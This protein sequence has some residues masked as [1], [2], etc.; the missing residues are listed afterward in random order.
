MEQGNI[1]YADD[2]G[3]DDWD[4]E[5]QEDNEI[6][7]SDSLLV[8]AM[9]E[10]EFSHLEVQVFSEDG[11]LFVHHDITLPDFPLSLAWMDCP[12]FATSA[13]GS[14]STVGN[15]IAVGTFSPAIEIWNLDV[16]DPLEPTAILGGENTAATFQKKQKQNKNGKKSKTIQQVA[17]TYLP[18]SHEAAVMSLSW[19]STFR[20]ALASG[21]ADKTVKIWDITTQACSHTFT[22]HTDKVQSVSWHSTE[23]WLLATGSFDRTIGLVDARSASTTTACTLG[24]D[25]ESVTWNPFN[26]FH[27]YCALEDGTIV[28]VDVRNCGNKG[29][30][31]AGGGSSKK[32]GSKQADA[33]AFSFQAH[34]L[35]ASQI[36]FSPR[37]PGMLATAS[38]DKTVKVWDVNSAGEGGVPR[39]V[40]YK[41]MNV[42]KLFAMQYNPDDAFLLAAAGDT[43]MVAVWESDEQEVIESYFKGRVVAPKNH[44]GSLREQQAAAAAASGSG[45]EEALAPA[46]KSSS[47]IEDDS[48]M[49]SNED[50][51]EELRKK[52]SKSGTKSKKT[53]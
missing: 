31:A 6:K 32:G 3:E 20:Q 40:A 42:G 2:M 21:S 44:Y 25:L 39:C 27:L 37:V 35:T 43:G 53:K 4:P 1:A 41:T 8:V 17:P 15:Y 12:P 48:W 18:G 38:I 45:M 23:A 5:D 50:P 9:T 36:S 7:A 52:K 19:N 46:M 14:Q 22:H 30:A 29:T 10:D 49:E 34:E 51:A 28:C 26:P 11:N 47:A 24:S 13:D 33:V 16:L